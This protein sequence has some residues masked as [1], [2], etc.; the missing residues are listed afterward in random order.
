VKLIEPAGEPFLALDPSLWQIHALCTVTVGDWPLIVV[1][2]RYGYQDRIDFFDAGSGEAVGGT[3]LGH[4][5][6]N[7][8]SLAF[9]IAGD[10]LIGGSQG[11]PLRRWAIPSGEFLGEW[12]PPRQWDS[13]S[14]TPDGATV[15]VVVGNAV[16]QHD[17]VTGRRAGPRLT[18]GHWPGKENL[19]AAA[20]VGPWVIACDVKGTMRIWRTS[21]EVHA[22]I[23]NAH[24][25]IVRITAYEVDGRQYAVTT[26]ADCT[27]RL[28][29]VERAEQIRTV[30]RMI[31]E[32]P[33]AAYA[34]GELLVAGDLEIRRF[35]PATGEPKGVLARF[36]ADDPDF[37]LGGD[38][39]FAEFIDIKH[40]CT[41]QHAVHFATAYAVWRLP[42]SAFAGP[43]G[44]SHS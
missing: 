21:G 22:V 8:G 12:R 18:A 42:E 39:E 44:H 43:G 35:D 16:R 17:A 2:A 5:D 34:H 26:G 13:F 29:D 40:I 32:P 10:T 28:W 37:E 14:V 24:P 15:L 36:A 9:A 31:E 38:N 11:W 1:A 6:R 19:R 30:T 7:G 41:A 3:D 23:R 33:W 20:S 27:V 25:W 4:R